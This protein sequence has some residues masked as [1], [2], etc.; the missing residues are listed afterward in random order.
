MYS[1]ET[2]NERFEKDRNSERV[3]ESKAETKRRQKSVSINFICRSF[4]THYR[5]HTRVLLSYWTSQQSSSA[6]SNIRKH[7]L[8]YIF[9]RLFSWEK[10]YDS[11]LE[12]KHKFFCQFMIT[13]FSVGIFLRNFQLWWLYNIFPNYSLFP[14]GQMLCFELDPN[15]FLSRIL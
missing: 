5:P 4:F 1:T 13:K 3:R 14:I 12:W 9:W 2:I 7:S 11:A 6:C 8:F 10:I 15:S